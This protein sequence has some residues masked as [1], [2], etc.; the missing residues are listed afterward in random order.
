MFL[1]LSET[2]ISSNQ[3]LAQ[4]F[5]AAPISESAFQFAGAKSTI[6]GVPEYLWWYGCSPTAGGMLIAY[7]DNQPGYQNL[8]EGDVSWQNPAAKNMVASSEHI[9][10]YWTN[11]PHP[12]PDP[13][14]NPAGTHADN[15]IAD[16]MHTSRSAEG[17]LDGGTA[18]QNI[19]IGLRDY[20]A[21]DDPTTTLTNEHYVFNSWIEWI[22]YPGNPEP[23]TF[24]DLQNEIDAAGISRPMELGLLGGLGGHSIVAL[25]YD[26]AAIH[27]FQIKVITSIDLS[28]GQITGTE[29]RTVPGILVN[30]TWSD[31]TFQSGALSR[32]VTPNWG[33]T[34]P[35]FD[36]D[37]EW[38]PYIEGTGYNWKFA[39][40][41]P[42][43]DW[44]VYNGTFFQ[45]GQP[46]P[47]PVPEPSTIIL[48]SFGLL[49]LVGFSLKRKSG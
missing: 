41:Q 6:A 20:A 4:P 33:L 1:L 29:D 7:W 43:D 28:T 11:A 38:W 19:P 17:T 44:Y 16:F 21:W 8:V 27:S 36:A 25:G 30:D 14:P 35:I 45:P 10:D 3:V 12:N 40:G 2:G 49:G 37:G 34:G 39:N 23:F 5:Q 24:N 18:W 15:C 13:D 31:H 32:W 9:A 48:F 47:P 42:L 22:N 46:A 26:D